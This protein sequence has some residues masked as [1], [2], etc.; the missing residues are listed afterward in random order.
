MAGSNWAQLL[1][2]VSPTPDQAEKQWW[3]AIPAWCGQ[4]GGRR[5]HKLHPGTQRLHDSRCSVADTAVCSPFLVHAEGEEWSWQD[6][7]QLA[8]GHISSETDSGRWGDP[9]ASW[10]LY[11]GGASTAGNGRRCG[12]KPWARRYSYVYI[13]TRTNQINWRHVSYI[14]STSPFDEQH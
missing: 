12:V 4:L 2:H 5:G 13:I 1:P 7:L 14:S 8:E 3:S 10:K 11:G 9:A 6:T